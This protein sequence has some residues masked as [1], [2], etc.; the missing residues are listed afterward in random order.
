MASRSRSS[1]SESRRSNAALRRHRVSLRAP[2][3]REYGGSLRLR[4]PPYHGDAERARAVHRREDR[5]RAAGRPHGFPDVN[6]RGYAKSGH[7]LV[8]RRRPHRRARSQV[9]DGTT[10]WSQG[11][12]DLSRWG[13]GAE[14]HHQADV[15]AAEPVEAT[16]PV[17]PIELSANPP[18]SLRRRCRGRHGRSAGVPAIALVPSVPP[19]LL[20]YTSLIISGFSQYFGAPSSIT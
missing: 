2:E 10:W 19:D 6:A 9:P 12:G 4:C 14:R 1:I 17:L 15:L 13:V 18:R 20:T 8:D 11:L 7:D 16:F 3:P 5:W